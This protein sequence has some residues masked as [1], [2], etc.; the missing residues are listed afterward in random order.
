MKAKLPWLNSISFTRS[1]QAYSSG[2]LIDMRKILTLTKI[3][4]YS[5]QLFF[6]LP[7]IYFQ[8]LNVLYEGDVVT[9]V[10]FSSQ[11]NFFHSNRS[12]WLTCC[13]P[14]DHF[15]ALTNVTVLKTT[16]F[17]FN[18]A[19]QEELKWKNRPPKLKARSPGYLMLSCR[20]Y[21]CSLSHTAAKL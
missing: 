2:K 3:T 20:Q 18:R 8:L 13:L 6:F 19:W 12:H 5:M 15:R 17:I 14:V 7:L 1:M 9:Q 4:F 11:G 16:T 21:H 10:W